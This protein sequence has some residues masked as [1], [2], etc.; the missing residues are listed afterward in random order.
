MH[1]NRIGRTVGIFLA[2]QTAHRETFLCIPQRVLI[3]ELGSSESLHGSTQTRRVDECEH[4]VQT[5]V[6][7]SNQ[8]TLSFIE[9]QLTCRRSVA[10]HFVFD[11][12]DIDVVQITD[13]PISTY[14]FFRNSKETDSF[15]T[16]RCV[17]KSC[18]DAM[19]NVVREVMI[20]ATDK[21][22]GTGDLVL[23]H[24]TFRGLPI[25]GHSLCGH[26][27]Q[28][29]S[30]RRF[31]ETH[32]ACPLTGNEL[33]QKLVLERFGRVR[34]QRVDR[35]LT[36]S[37]KHGPSPI[38]CGKDIR[39]KQRERVRHSHAT[40]LLGKGKTLPTAFDENVVR[41]LESGGSLHLGGSKM[42]TP[43]LIGYLVQGNEQFLRNLCRLIEN[44]IEHTLRLIFHVE[45]FEVS[46]EIVYFVDH[47]LHV[48]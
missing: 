37:R 43:F 39:L 12:T 31:R 3:R 5:F 26:L 22:L 30:T 28:V 17:R 19:E 24:S 36:E 46:V 44:R 13:R 20:T 14:D 16:R 34:E 40:V 41:V 7:G 29:R 27:T 47:E 18:Q 42:S 33:I 11:S 35:S 8:V 45:L 32:R 38:R 23:L 4:V 9:V 15:R 25:D 6:F 1:D 10:S 21:D 48:A 2:S